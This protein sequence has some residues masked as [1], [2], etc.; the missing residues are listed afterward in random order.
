[1]KRGFKAKTLPP[2]PGSSETTGM[3]DK[4]FVSWMAA[5]GAHPTTRKRREQL[6]KAGLW[7]EA[8]VAP[9]ACART[10]LG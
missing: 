9:A 7:T 4:E 6:R 10:S 2:V 3:T 1:M 5:Q 8:A